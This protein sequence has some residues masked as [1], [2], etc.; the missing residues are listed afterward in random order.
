MARRSSRS[1]GRSSRTTGRAAGGSSSGRAAAAPSPASATEPTPEAGLTARIAFAL[2]AIAFIA[3]PMTYQWT[4]RPTSRPLGSELLV[5]LL[6]LGAIIAAGAALLLG[7]RARAAG[8]RSSGAVWAPR[9]GGAAIV[10]YAMV[11]FLLVSR[12]R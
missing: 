12:A 10:G 9:L 4:F 1:S 3:L 7:R 5:Q 8:D 2:G 11:F 6:E